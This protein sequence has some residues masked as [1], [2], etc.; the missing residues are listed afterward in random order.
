M[1]VA[2]TGTGLP[3][4]A[5]GPPPRS[6][7]AK[8][9][10]RADE[11]GAQL[12]SECRGGWSNRAE[13]NCKWTSQARRSEPNRPGRK[14][15]KKLQ[16]ENKLGVLRLW[17]HIVLRRCS[18]KRQSKQYYRESVRGGQAGTRIRRRHLL[19]YRAA[20]LCFADLFGSLCC[21][22]VYCPMICLLIMMLLRQ[23]YRRQIHRQTDLLSD[24]SI[25]SCSISSLRA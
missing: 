16:K 9:L 19:S 20:V 21:W 12:P 3:A 6:L 24:H 10:P 18:S 2:M 11:A 5:S 25:N 14:L 7:S 22:L 1:V 15:A 17:F 13:Q 8:A 23:R 4:P